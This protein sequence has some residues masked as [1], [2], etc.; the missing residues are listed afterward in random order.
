MNNLEIFI[1]GNVPSSKNGKRWTGKYLIHSKTTMR[2][3]K[4]SKE[5]YLEQTYPFKEFIE[6][7]N[8]PYVIHFKFYRKSRRKFDYVNPLQTVQDLMVKYHWLEDDSSDHLLP[9]FDIY[10]YN[11]ENPG[12]LITIKDKEN[13]KNKTKKRNTLHK[14]VRLSKNTQNNNKSTG[15]KRPRKH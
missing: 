15:N 3:I 9:I 13:V 6:R 4:E 8:P 14:T 7:F 10:E 1:N 2:Y 12:V 5:E 11:K